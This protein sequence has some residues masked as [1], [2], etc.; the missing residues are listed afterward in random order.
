MEDL[1]DIKDNISMLLE[2]TNRKQALR[3]L[4]EILDEDY[5]LSVASNIVKADCEPDL[6]KRMFEECF[7]SEGNEGAGHIKLKDILNAVE[8]IVNL[9]DYISEDICFEYFV[10]P[11]TEEESEDEGRNDG[12]EWW[13][14]DKSID[15]NKL[16]VQFEGNW[17]FKIMVLTEER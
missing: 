7:Y 15:I 13:T 17:Y 11:E 12:I 2:E 10:R 14:R 16:Y 6:N 8:E 9:D 1:K 4:G 3:I 5:D